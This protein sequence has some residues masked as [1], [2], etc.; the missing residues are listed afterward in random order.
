M[1][2]YV[3]AVCVSHTSGKIFLAACKNMVVS[4]ISHIF[5]GFWFAMNA[6][7]RFLSKIHDANCKV[8]MANKEIKIQN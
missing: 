1:G 7:I 2:N 3:W 8:W 5:F 4:D 6:K